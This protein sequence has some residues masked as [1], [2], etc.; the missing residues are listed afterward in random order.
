[1]VTVPP[2]RNRPEE[3]AM[4][5]ADEL[6]RAAQPL[7]AHVSL[8]EQCLLRPWPGNV[9]E[10]LVE[11]RAAAQAAAAESSARVQATHLAA[12]AGAPFGNAAATTPT[13]AAMTT[14]PPP[15][16]AKKRA[17]LVDDDWKRRIEEA[18]RANGG[19]VTASA[20]ALGLHRTQ[21]RRLLER[22]GIAVTDDSE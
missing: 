22:H 7:A 1:M 18:L 14:A 21:L 8:I 2:L 6:R 13:A 5:V 17:P 12:S 19:N 15:A 11:V 9:R 4:I 10:L 16:D 20:R 3:I